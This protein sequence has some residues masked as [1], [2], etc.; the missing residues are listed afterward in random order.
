MRRVIVW[1]GGAVL[2]LLI[3]GLWVLHRLGDLELPD[4]DIS[5][6]QLE[7]GGVRLAGT[8]VLPRGRPDAPVAIIVHGDGPQDR[9]SG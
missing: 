9:W 1:W 8:L 3:A 5:H 2:L 7:A 6:H 4:A